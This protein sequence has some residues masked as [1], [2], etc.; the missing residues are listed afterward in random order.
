MHSPHQQVVQFLTLGCERRVIA[1]MLVHL[2]IPVLDL[3][4]LGRKEGFVGFFIVIHILKA[5][6]DEETTKNHPHLEACE[7]AY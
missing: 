4:D 5:E 3:R 2:T 7:S 6:A 1:V